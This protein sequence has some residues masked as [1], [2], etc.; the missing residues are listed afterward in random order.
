MR[1]GPNPPTE[2]RRW[3]HGEGM[4]HGIWLEN[5]RARRYRNRW[6]RPAG[7]DT[8]LTPTLDGTP[9]LRGSPANTHIIN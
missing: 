7:F 8:P 6:V 2:K 4:L 1:N 5:G 3:F 9:D